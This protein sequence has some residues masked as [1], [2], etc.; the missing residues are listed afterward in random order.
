MK[1]HEFLVTMRQRGLRP[2]DVWLDVGANAALV[3]ALQEVNRL[4]GSHRV[5]IERGDPIERLDLRFVMGC[6]VYV[7]GEDERDVRRVY[8]A[9]V[10]H[11]A[12]RVIAWSPAAML[13]TAGLL[14]AA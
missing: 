4:G 1:H 9:A 12:E 5:A 8:D 11:K 7:H 3:D 6:T 14:E 10:K 13:D 2:A